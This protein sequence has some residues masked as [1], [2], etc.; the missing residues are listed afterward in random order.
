[1]SAP[2]DAPR[3]THL[4]A[5]RTWL[6]WWRTWLTAAVAALGVGRI[7][8]EIVDG[9]SWPYVA[10]GSAY[11]VLGAVILALA[12][13]RQRAVR[14][15]LRQGAYDE[16]SDRWVVVLSGGGVVLALATLVLVLAD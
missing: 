2:D 16:L 5:E 1:V 8:P 12:A 15:S 4:A 11:A 14:R 7:A 6:A 10:I 13:A 9:A 3:R